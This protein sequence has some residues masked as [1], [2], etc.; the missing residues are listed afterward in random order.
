MESYN[1]A[2]MPSCHHATLFCRSWNRAMMRS[3]THHCHHIAITS[4]SHRHHIAI[5]SPSLNPFLFFISYIVLGNLSLHGLVLPLSARLI[6]RLIEIICSFFFLLLI[7]SFLLP[8]FHP[9]P[10]PY[11]LLLS[12]I[13][14][15]FSLSTTPTLHPFILFL[16]HNRYSLP[17]SNHPLPSRYPLLPPSICCPFLFDHF[18]FKLRE[19]LIG[20]SH[21][22]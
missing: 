7:H 6:D 9:F 12:S 16:L 17:P 11:L 4:P 5:A 2:V 22:V 15:S 20:L 3:R 1:P 13:L 18:S 14:S 10:S 8:S 21:V 19:Y